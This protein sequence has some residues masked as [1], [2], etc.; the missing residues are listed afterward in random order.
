[1]TND[2]L[3][4]VVVRPPNWA[5]SRSASPYS[6]IRFTIGNE[7]FRPL[8]RALTARVLFIVSLF[9]CALI[10]TLRMS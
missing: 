7:Y 5:F 8:P 2:Q 1:M 10:D 3:G 9:K 6:N 4:G